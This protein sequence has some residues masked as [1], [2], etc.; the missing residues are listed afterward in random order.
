MKK[1]AGIL[2]NTVF[3]LLIVCLFI[4]SIFWKE[5][6]IFLENMIADNSIASAAIFI[7]LMFITTVIAPLAMLP[8]VPMIAPFFG[9]FLTA[10]YTIVGWGFGAIVAFLLARHIG[11][12]LLEK[13]VSLEE[14]EK[15]ES[16]I[17]ENMTFWGLV[18]LRMVV[19]VDILSYALGFLSK[20][21]LYRYS[22]ATIIG[23]S[24]F[25]FLFSYMG[26]SFLD[27][28]YF[29]FTSIFVGSLVMFIVVFYLLIKNKK[30]GD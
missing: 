15:Y 2:L 5:P 25:A 13:I 7:F 4:V 21:P 9:P 11:R 24:P 18:L 8:M 29:V 27:G 22:L 17:P 14:I 12:P 28:D 19:P 3:V 16:R 30:L 26:D 10:I 20:I 6:V 23:I 1:T